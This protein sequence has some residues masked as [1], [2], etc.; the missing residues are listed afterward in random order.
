MFYYRPSPTK[1]VAAA[2]SPLRMISTLCLTGLG[3]R[4]GETVEALSSWGSFVF[5]MVSILV[6]TPLAALV[7]LRLPLQPPELAFGLAVF[8]CMPTTLSSGVSLT[9]VGHVLRNCQRHF[10]ILEYCF[11]RQR[12]GHKSLPDRRMLNSLPSL[13]FVYAHQYLGHVA[14]SCI[15]QVD[16]TASMVILCRIV[17][18]DIMGPTASDMWRSYQCLVDRRETRHS[19]TWRQYLSCKHTTSIHGPQCESQPEFWYDQIKLECLIRVSCAG[20]RRKYSTRIASHNWKQSSGHFY[21][22]IC[23]VHGLRVWTRGSQHSARPIACL[24]AQVHLGTLAA[25]CCCTCIHSRQAPLPL[26][27]ALQRQASV[28]VQICSDHFGW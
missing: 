12:V 17:P 2:V 23:V 24:P 26:A 3:M 1:I 10:I 16:A 21:D 5:G 4:K 6:I 27:A 19:A 11:W 15:T 28:T 25:W 13:W 8:C 7:A 22:A 9:Q 14:R 20:N 18:C